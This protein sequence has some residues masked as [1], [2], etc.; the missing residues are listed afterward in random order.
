MAGGADHGGVPIE[1]INAIRRLQ[2]LMDI[3]RVVGGDES[4]PTVLDAIARV[5][6]DTVGFAGV[7]INVYRPQFD[8]YEAAVVLGPDEMR[9]TLLGATYA[10]SWIDLV[11]DE[12]F[13]QRGG[14]LHPRGLGRLEQRRRRRALHRD[15]VGPA[16]RG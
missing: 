3:T 16:R 14:V 9:E 15:A 5:L 13:D 2:A 7:V 12:R 6:T 4:I 1:D 8:D 10:A 11:L